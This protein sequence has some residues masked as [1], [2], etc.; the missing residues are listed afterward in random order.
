MIS[1]ETRRIIRERANFSCEYCGV[2][3]TEAGGELTIDHFQPQSKSGTDELENLIY[4][5]PRC[6]LYK[7]D[8]FPENDSDIPL[9]NPRVEADD[10]HFLLLASGKLSPFTAIGNFTIQRLRL[11][12]SPLIE[13]RRQ[14]QIQEEEKRLISEYQDLVELLMRESE[15][16]VLLSEQQQKL[17][18]E[19]QRLLKKLFDLENK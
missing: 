17:L 7:G 5:C 19:Q 8:Y 6:N 4:A 15:T 16:Q 14:K 12:R 9:W 2:S 10:Q 3:E 13:H 1:H 11:N 18:Q